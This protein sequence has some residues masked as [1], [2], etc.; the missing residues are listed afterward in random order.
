MPI[1]A[2]VKSQE[3]IPPTPE[4]IEKSQSGENEAEGENTTQKMGYVAMS[5]VVIFRDLNLYFA[6]NV[7]Y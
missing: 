6:C 5:N 7:F 3:L 2:E 4:E 1:I